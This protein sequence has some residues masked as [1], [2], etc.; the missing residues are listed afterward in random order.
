MACSIE[1]SPVP[2]YCAQ[3]DLD[4]AEGPCL[5]APS[6]V[7]MDA[8][9]AKTTEYEAERMIDSTVNMAAHK[10]SIFHALNDTRI[11][12]GKIHVRLKRYDHVI[13]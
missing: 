10:L 12:V 7:D 5:Q 11:V 3:N 1:L 4:T 6:L 9:V 13:N 2:Y 8:L